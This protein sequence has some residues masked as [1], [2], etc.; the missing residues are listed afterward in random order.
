VPVVWAPG[1]GIVEFPDASGVPLAPTDQVVVQMHYNLVDPLSHGKT[2]QTTLELRLEDHVE[3]VGLFAVVDPFLNTLFTGESADLPP[4]Q[5]SVK[6]NWK[7]SMVEM[8]VDQIPDLKLAGIMPHMHEL[9]RTFQM[10]VTGSAERCGIEIPS[11]DFHWQRMYFYDEP[12]SLAATDSLQVTCD[13]D[14]SSRSEPVLPGWGTQ[15][16][17]CAA[18]VYV[19]A[20]LE[21]FSD[22]L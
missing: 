7:Q 4:G 17:M 1:Q 15:N 3:R 10:S 16:E 2:D 5:S 22:S 11:W 21:A 19:T 12:L 6:Y 13:F 18:I 14:T 9:G 8:E 20:P